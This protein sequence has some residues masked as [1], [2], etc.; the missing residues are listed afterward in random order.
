MTVSRQITITKEKLRD[1][2][3]LYKLK[4]KKELLKATKQQITDI[5][6]ENTDN[7]AADKAPHGRMALELIMGFCTITA[8]INEHL[9]YSYLNDL[10]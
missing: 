2:G 1:N 4:L 3:D 6:M 5:V 8:R 10:I 9:N 7:A